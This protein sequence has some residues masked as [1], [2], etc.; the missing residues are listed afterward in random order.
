MPIG[1]SDRVAQCAARS[2]DSASYLVGADRDVARKALA[3]VHG[4]EATDTAMQNCFGSADKFFTKKWH[5]SQRRLRHPGVHARFC[6][7]Q[8]GK[9]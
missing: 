5:N 6:F 1:S 7:H 8:R 9:K 3:P 2:S 4:D